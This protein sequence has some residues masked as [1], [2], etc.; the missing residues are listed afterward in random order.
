[1]MGRSRLFSSFLLFAGACT[2]VALRA[3]QEL[4]L[5]GEFGLYVW[6]SRD[7]VHV[8]WLTQE[9]APGTL[10]VMADGK[11][12][13]TTNTP[14]S[15][16]HHAAFRKPKSDSF[17]INYGTV[18]ETPERATTTIFRQPL[19]ATASAALPDT[20]YVFGDTHGEFDSVVRLMQHA[21]LIDQQLRWTGGKKQIVFLGDVVDRGPDAMRLLWYLYQLE[22]EADASGGHVHVLLGNHEIMVMLGDVRYVH[23]KETR[24][25]QLHGVKYPTLVN[26]RTSVLG[27]WLASK[28]AVLKMGDLLLVHGGVSSDYLRE[29]PGSLARMVNQNIRSDL[30]MAYTDSTVRVTVDSASFK[31]FD[32][33]FWG[34]RSLFWY[35]G[36]AMSDTL[37]AELTGTL[38]SFGAQTL[39]IGHTP[40]AHIQQKYQGKLII[41]H[42]RRPAG[43]LLLITGRGANRQ[44]HRLLPDGTAELFGQ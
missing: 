3:P 37:D 19:N 5:A 1:M 24:I 40:V 23:G 16:A 35:R 29:S 18:A 13:F 44:L 31:Q 4:R 43:E 15:V 7:S 28:P 20:L 25:A 12:Y 2:L 9:N 6:E 22:R 8:Q 27:R 10:L 32:Q 11:P 41:A 21:R 34:D 36:Y 30:F 14:T 38:N 26:P 42:P 39:I 33:F 17:A